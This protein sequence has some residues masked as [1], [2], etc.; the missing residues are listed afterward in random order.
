MAAALTTTGRLVAGV[1]C[2]TQATKVEIR[3]VDSG[4]IIAT[5]S[6][7]HP[8]S[9][10]PR[11]EQPPAAWWAAFEQAWAQAGSPSVAA[12]SVAA[13]Q[14][15]MVALDESGAVVRDAKLWNDTET[16]PDAGWLLKQLP[17][18]AAEW[19][20]R[21]GTVPVAALTIS[22]LSWLH[23]SEPD[24]WARMAKVVLPHDWMTAQLTGAPNDSIST[25]RGDASGTGYWS[26]ATGEYDWDLLAIVDADRD[27]RRAVP[28]VLGPMEV[29]GQWRGSVVA[30]GTGDNM[31]AAL[32]LGIDVG[33][34]VIS[35]GTSG[36]VSTV[37]AS[38]VSDI[39][40]AVAGFADATGRFLPL[41]CTLNATRV[42]D[43]VARLLGVGLDELAA[44][45]LATPA[46][47][48][49]M[50]LLP[51]FDGERVPNRPK[52]TG[53]LSGMRS[54]VTREQLARA[55][56]EGVV[57]SLLDGFDALSRHTAAA[58]RIVLVGGGARSQAYRQVFA[59]LC[60]LPVV[61]A[62][63]VEAVATGA[64]VQAASVLD[65]R[66]AADV[67][68]QWALDSTAAVD[69]SVALGGAS[70]AEVR[71]A[72]VALRDRTG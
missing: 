54:D 21:C 3:D 20:E 39:S 31:A 16:A 38:P 18:G 53:W 66:S 35:I 19:A 59:D 72:Y 46:G 40:G 63:A 37:S 14:H 67:S 28:R 11:S 60:D 26:A 64:C 23:R 71:A 12:I 7:A 50:T 36:T 44:M 55:A 43:A 34:V 45:A 29:A 52:S 51:Y 56:Y 30:S 57:C 47:A 65:Q 58:Q 5:G 1:D 68:A 48:G 27:W 62:T 25:D 2:S 15:G 24:N 42:T 4:E 10:P 33:D 61:V 13:Q 49:G 70:P 6:V 69:R 8:Q 22:K 41:V 9:T 17:D 32:G